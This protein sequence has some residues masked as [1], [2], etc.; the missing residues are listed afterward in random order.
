MY[1]KEEIPKIRINLFFYNNDFSLDQAKTLKSLL[2]KY[3]FFPPRKI[4]AGNLTKNRVLN[5]KE[6]M[7]DYFVESMISDNSI[8]FGMSSISNKSEN[9][10]W[11]VDIYRGATEKKLNFIPT[12]RQWG[13]ITIDSTYGRLGVLDNLFNLQSLMFELIDFVNPFYGTVEDIS[14]SV[15]LMSKTRE[16]RFVPG[17]PQNVY[18]GNY[19]SKE[20]CEI[21]DPDVIRNLP[22]M[23][24]VELKNGLYF[25]FEGEICYENLVS[26]LKDRV[27]NYKLLLKGAIHGTQI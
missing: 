21:F 20:Y 23:N 12:Y 7:S 18:W 17:F 9:E 1:S 11:Q 6:N 2:M 5:F 13:I 25:S 16:K 19:F 15:D 8:G 4:Y 14:I 22:S 3:N 27:N 10:Y 26:T 24:I